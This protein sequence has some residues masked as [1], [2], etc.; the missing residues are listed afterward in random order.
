M[1]SQVRE[2]RISKSGEQTKLRFVC[3]KLK[4]CGSLDTINIYTGLCNRVHVDNKNIKSAGF[5]RVGNSVSSVCVGRIGD[6]HAISAI[7]HSV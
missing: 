6:V 3:P 7:F 5:S 4:S 1:S 2:S